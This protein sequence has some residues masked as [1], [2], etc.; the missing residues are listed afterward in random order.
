MPLAMFL[1]IER[2]GKSVI[3]T[4]APRLWLNIRA[5][6]LVLP[7]RGSIP[8]TSEAILAPVAV[9]QIN[10][11]F[12]FPTS[13]VKQVYPEREAPLINFPLASVIEESEVEIA[14]ESEVSKIAGVIGKVEAYIFIPKASN[15]IARMESEIFL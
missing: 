2:A 8:R 12:G 10:S 14:V 9:P 13:T 4:S 3:F 15:E 6:T 11:I 1:M 5:V 7:S